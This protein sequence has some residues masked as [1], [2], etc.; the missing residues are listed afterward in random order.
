MQYLKLGSPGVAV[1][2][3]CFRPELIGGRGDRILEQG[4]LTTG[5]AIDLLTQPFNL[6]FAESWN[7]LDR[8]LGAYLM[9]CY[10]CLPISPACW[11]PTF[12]PLSLL[13][14]FP[15]YPR[16]KS[17]KCVAFSF[18]PR[19]QEHAENLQ[20]EKPSNRLIR[21]QRAEMLDLV[22]S[23]P[24]IKRQLHYMNFFRSYS[25]HDNEF[26]TRVSASSR[27]RWKL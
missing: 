20:F 19:P 2:G 7:L 18:T 16:I 3:L 14:N 24:S 26:R 8:Q 6:L 25:R 4:S 17:K 15:A 13:S 5:G 23:N 9:L 12:I 22:G 27:R 21:F 10:A 11:Y 1:I